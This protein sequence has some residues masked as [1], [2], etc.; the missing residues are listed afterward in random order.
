MSKTSKIVDITKDKPHFVEEYICIKCG[1]RYLGVRPQGTL[2]KDLQ[3]GLC[4]ATGFVI[5]TGQE[6]DGVEL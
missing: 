3:C 6:L 2:L 4:S 1:Y 5:K